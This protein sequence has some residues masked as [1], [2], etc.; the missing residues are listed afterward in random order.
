MCVCVC[1]CVCE[2]SIIKTIGSP[3][4]PDPLLTLV[5]IDCIPVFTFDTL[6]QR[7]LVLPSL[8]LEQSLFDL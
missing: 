2:T 1:V 7:V 6:A 4:A 8:L 3:H 5:P